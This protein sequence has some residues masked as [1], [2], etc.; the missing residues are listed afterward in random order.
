MCLF[1]NSV[2]SSENC[3]ICLQDTSG[4]KGVGKFLIA[5]EDSSYIVYVLRT[6]QSQ[7]EILT[8]CMASKSCFGFKNNVDYNYP[9][10]EIHNEGVAMYQKT[11]TFSES[12]I[13]RKHGQNVPQQQTHLQCVKAMPVQ[14]FNAMEETQVCMSDLAKST[15]GVVHWLK[16]DA[17]YDLLLLRL[18]EGRTEA[19]FKTELSKLEFPATNCAVLKLLSVQD[20]YEDYYAQYYSS[21]LVMNRLLSTSQ[22]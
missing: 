5:M 14:G 18:N 20:C 12:G 4:S 17:N 7:N 16:F 8:P 15:K 21:S 3:R 1:Q 22:R 13:E 19:D 2:S 9:C 10:D 6:L 11:S